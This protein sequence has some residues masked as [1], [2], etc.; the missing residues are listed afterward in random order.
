MPH[1]KPGDQTAMALIQ[2][3]CVSCHGPAKQK[4]EVRLDTLGPVVDEVSAELWENIQ[5]AVEDGLMPPKDEPALKPED[6][7]LIVSEAVRRLEQA[8]LGDAAAQRAPMRRMTRFQYNN[9]VGDLL[10]LRVDLFALPEQVIRPHGNYFDPASGKMP[11][12]VV[13]GNRPLGAGQMIQRRLDGVAPYPK[14]LR[15]E[16]GFDNR[17]DHL[18]LSPLLMEEFLR[19]SRSIVESRDFGPKTV[20]SWNWLFQPPAPK[21]DLRQALD[22]RLERLLMHAFRGNVKDEKR[23]RYAAFVLDE[24]EAGTG[25]TAAIK[26]AVSAVLISPKFLYLYSPGGEGDTPREDNFAL[27]SRLSFFLWASIPDQELLELSASGKLSDPKVLE[28]QLSR[29]LKDPKV[30]RFCDSFPTQWLHLE[31]LF[32]AKPDADLFPQYYS[33]NQRASSHLMLEPLLLFETVYVENRSILE[34]IDPDYSYQSDVVQ[35]WMHNSNKYNTGKRVTYQTSRLKF[36]RIKLKDRREGGVITNAAVMSMLAAPDESKPISRGEWVASVIFNDPPKPAP[37]D[38]PPLSEDPEKIAKMTLRERL[39]AHRDFPA[40]AACHEKID[41]LGFALENYSPAGTW[42]DNYS[43]GLAVDASGVLFG[44]HAFSTPA[45]LK[46]AILLE[47]DRFNRAFAKHLLSYATSREIGAA[48]TPAL[49]K[50]AKA[51][52]EDG[53]KLRTLIREVVFS[54]TFRGQK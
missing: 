6:R 21:Q 19:L 18:S 37:A 36:D 11:N 27:A 32:S 51:S 31:K 41:P 16:H 44:K 53:Y 15:A 49:N 39:S 8:Q 1:A 9:A 29:M 38:V 30:K 7:K 45:E 22:A 42:R 43:N 47:K 4:G 35:N 54:E 24:I 2:K 3:H 14:D 17:G 13:V 33:R 48:D 28:Q 52:A 23:E 5:Y 12:T 10:Q 20:G 26:K 46:D 40:C 34:L 50:I 25:F